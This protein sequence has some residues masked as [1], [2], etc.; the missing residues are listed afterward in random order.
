MIR[1]NHPI[2]ARSLVKFSALI[3]LTLGLIGWGSWT[4]LL[5]S[6]A[7]ADSV[8]LTLPPGSSVLKV[9]QLLQAHNLIRSARVFQLY[10]RLNSLSIQAGDYTLEPQSLPA[11]ALALTSGR[12]AEI[13]VTIPEGYRREQIAELFSAKLSLDPQAFLNA[14]EG[15]EGYLFPDTYSFLQ[16][17]SVATAVE[18]LQA[19]FEKKA[20]SLNLTADDVT[21]ASII[22]REALTP[23][24]KPVVSG[25]LKNRLA[26]GWP[27]EVDASIQFIMGKSGDW[28]PTPLLGDRSRKSL[29]NTY[30]N[31]GLPPGPICNPGLLSLQAAAAPASTPYFFYLHDQDGRIHYATTNAEHEANIAKY[32]TRASR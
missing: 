8:T 24:E 2:A 25:I 30:Q 22:E 15:L 7:Q 23:A 28:W 26:A 12:Q 16:G 32:I 29:Y 17:T 3:L 4:Y 11:L 1:R 21:L 19:N 27:L 10:V 5:T 14:T 18:T 31:R 6:P 20:R 13:R 9:G